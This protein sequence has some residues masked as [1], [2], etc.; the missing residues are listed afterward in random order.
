MKCSS[1]I[2]SLQQQHR[3]TIVQG[4]YCCCTS[5]LLGGLTQTW[6]MAAIRDCMQA[7]EGVPHCKV[8]RMKWCH[9]DLGAVAYKWAPF[10]EQDLRFAPL[11][12]PH[13]FTSEDALMA[14]LV[15]KK[16]WAVGH[17]NNTCL[18][19]QG[20][21]PQMCARL[22]GV[23]CKLLVPRLLAACS[24]QDHR[25]VDNF[26]RAQRC[27]CRLRARRVVHQGM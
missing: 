10:I 17:A 7:K 4:Q 18:F 12:A 1:A 2:R 23:P 16:G 13:R 25:Q 5:C 8:N 11:H 9:T 27:S 24:C 22:G 14:E 20:P 3:F 26:Q 19:D 15:V 6:C 21:S